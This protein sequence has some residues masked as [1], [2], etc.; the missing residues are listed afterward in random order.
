MITVFQHW[1]S[2]NNSFYNDVVRA[3]PNILQIVILRLK[4]LVQSRDF[5][6]ASQLVVDHIGSTVLVNGVVRQ[7]HINICC[8]VTCRLSVP[9]GGKP[10]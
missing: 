4:P 8:V 5:S 3:G 9:T 1:M 7:M 10:V 2:C 6:F